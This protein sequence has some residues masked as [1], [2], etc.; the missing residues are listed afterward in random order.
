MFKTSSVSNLRSIL[1]LYNLYPKKRWGQNFLI[2]Y[3]IIKKIIDTAAINQEDYIVEIGPG[4][5]ALT[6]ELAATA[7][8]VLAID[9][10]QNLA[11]PLHEILKTH[12]NSR[13]LFADILKIDIEKELK[14]A[15]SLTEIPSYKVCANIPYNI[16]TPIIFNLLEKSSRLKSATLMMQK[17]VASRILANPGTKDYGLLTIMVGYYA[18]AE[19][20]LNVSR[21][22]FYPKPEVDS[23]VIKLIPYDLPPVN[24]VNETIFKDFTKNAFQKRRKTLLNISSS[25]FK[26]EK[27]IA[28]SL[29]EEIGINPLHR[30]E[31]LSLDDL[32]KLVN[33]FL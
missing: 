32:A 4:L 8:G 11:E 26:I 5:G 12:K 22:C 24:I 17:E 10:D 13:L 33:A 7:K 21:N 20:G 31:N 6:Q 3:N 28:G 19:L 15:F 9:I 2:D 29:L 16:T 30:P 25:F 14:D 18:R 27:N 1:K 23:T